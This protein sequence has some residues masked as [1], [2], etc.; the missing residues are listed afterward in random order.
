MCQ[1]DKLLVP[2][3]ASQAGQLDKPPEVTTLF[4][5]SVYNVLANIYAE[6]GDDFFGSRNGLFGVGGWTIS[7]TIFVISI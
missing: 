1:A 4:C 7:K 5:Y 6:V 3:A 2:S